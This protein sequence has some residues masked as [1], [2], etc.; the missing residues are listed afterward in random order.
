MKNL[1]RNQISNLV[2]VTQI[3]LA[4]VV[5]TAL[6]ASFSY[7]QQA[8]PSASKA[9]YGKVYGDLRLRYETVSQD[10]PLPDAD[11]LTLRTQL[12]YKSPELN[13]FSG[14]IEV[15][16]S[17]SLV[18][19]FSVPP[20]GDRVGEFS[21]I[22]D[23]DHTEL[24][25]AFVQ[26]KSDSLT[27]K[28]GRQVFTLDGHRFVGHVGWRQDRQT[29]DGL[30]VNYKP[31]DN[32]EI[33]ASYIAQRNRIFA[34]DADLDSE[35]MILNSSYQTPY[36]KLVTYAYFLEVD[37]GTSNSLDTI[38]ASFA[39]K[40]KLGETAVLYTAEFATQE[41]N[42]TFDSDYLFVEAGVSQF[43]I[44]AKLGYE[45]LGSDQ[46][47]ASFQTPL[48][49]LHKFNGWADLFLVTPAQGLEDVYLSLSGK[50]AGGK[51][52]AVYHDFS[53]DIVVDGNSDLGDEI[54]LLYTRKFTDQFSGG[55]KY[56]DYSA[57]DQAFNRVD[58]ERLW[59]WGGFKF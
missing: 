35:D 57:G 11:G 55:L 56:A 51:W 17:V 44:T 32:F 29:F 37:N 5:I 40:Q 16:N 36:G 47:N 49:T 39:G 30:V 54:N 20:T 18:D 8:E 10:N 19:D 50:L 3:V 21:V 26:Y 58:T 45:T 38:G 28:L 42:D 22:A 9:N 59:V 7:A 15:E 23:P 48:A 27:A 34:E 4:A 14:V 2:S 31:L 33:N 53:S 43:G 13:G 41:L 25:Q 1:L 52:V 24:D 6:N 12:G 46:G